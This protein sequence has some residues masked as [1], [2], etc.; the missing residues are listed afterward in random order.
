MKKLFLFIFIGFLASSCQKD[1][2]LPNLGEKLSAV[3]FDDVKFYEFEYNVE[4]L[5]EAEKNKFF[6][7]RYNYD[8][9]LG[10][11]S[12]EIYFDSRLA[13]SN[14]GIAQEALNRLVWVTPQNTELTGILVFKFD[15]NNRLIKSTELNGYSE[16][17]FD[18]NDR[19]KTRRMYNE[20]KLSGTREYDYDMLG[21]VKTDTQYYVL[22]NGTKQLSAT[23]EYEYDNM[24]NPY[25]N[26][27][28]DRFHVENTNPNNITRKKYTVYNYPDAGL[29]ER[30]TYTYNS[31]GL[32]TDRND[33]MRYQYFQ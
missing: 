28:P 22:E 9:K 5:L 4:G 2:S 14:S 31:L 12:K 8:K 32:P 7:H 20:G 17:D 18:N 30:Y 23:T 13:S 33:G 21:N 15:A 29:E 26:L 6:Y 16:Y 24:K 10:T 25:Y 1:E 11:V 27:K 3:Y 19:I